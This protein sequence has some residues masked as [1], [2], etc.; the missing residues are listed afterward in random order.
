M[1]KLWPV[2]KV[3]GTELKLHGT[4]IA[5]LAFYALVSG[6]S[7]GWAAAIISLVLALTLFATVILHEL[8]HVYA[9]KRYDIQAKDIILTPLGGIARGLG[10]PSSPRQELV[11]AAAGPA[12]N[13]VLAGLAWLAIGLAPWQ[14][15]GAIGPLAFSFTSWFFEMNLVLGLFNLLPA[16]PMDGGR[17][18][19]A[20][21][22][23]K[24]SYLK[25]TLIAA[26][27]A[28]FTTL[29]MAIYAISIGSF[30]LF[31]IAAA[32]FLMSYSEQ[33]QAASQQQAGR[34]FNILRNISS[35]SNPS[36]QNVYPGGIVDQWGRPVSEERQNWTV[37]SIRWDNLKH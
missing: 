29:F 33:A 6:F 3:F 12:V 20:L 10:A 7:N 2:G 9:Y 34:V 15:M 30:T 11:I 17:I 36:Q 4:W 26:K 8:G 5:M 35:S 19:R 37:Q 21:L 22:A 25:A 27:V 1:W 18:L 32:V 13:A 14:A 16:L 23:M 24:L 28:R 31:F